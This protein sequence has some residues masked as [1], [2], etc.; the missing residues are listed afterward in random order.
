MTIEPALRERGDWLGASCVARYRDEGFL[1][2]A[3]IRGDVLELSGIGGK[4]EVGETFREAVLR[5]FEEETAVRPDRLVPVHPPRHLS[6]EAQE[7]PVPE[8]AAALIARRPAAHPSQG[9]LWIAVFLGVLSRAPQP[10][11]KVTHFAV[12]APGAFQGPAQGGAPD[13]GA[14]ALLEDGVPRPAAEVLPAQVRSVT[15]VDT[16]E[17]VLRVPDLLADWWRQSAPGSAASSP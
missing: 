8:G 1:F 12:L 17:A 7:V 10:V 9:L 13:L 14:L 4:V 16:A 6:P 5:E 11:E 15:A 2:A 3:A